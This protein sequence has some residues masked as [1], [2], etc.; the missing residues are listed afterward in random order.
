ML[1]TLLLLTSQ[2]VIANCNYTFNQGTKHYNKYL[3]QIKEAEEY[4]Q[5]GSKGTEDACLAFYEASTRFKQAQKL[6]TTCGGSFRDAVKRCGT[7]GDSTKQREAK[8]HMTLCENNRTNAMTRYEQ[9][10]PHI[11]AVCPR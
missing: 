10:Q 4:F 6:S 9:T 11:K 1:V 2:S 8:K 3:V 7:S 5:A